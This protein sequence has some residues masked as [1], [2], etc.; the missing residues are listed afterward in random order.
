MQIM[1]CFN[2]SKL[3]FFSGIKGYLINSFIPRKKENFEE[4]YGTITNKTNKIDVLVFIKEK[5]V[6]NIDVGSC[7]EIIGDLQ[8][9]GKS[10]L[11]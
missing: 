10:I 5:E 7:L 9:F 1:Y 4:Y 11:Y 8:E 3:N 2:Q 6:L